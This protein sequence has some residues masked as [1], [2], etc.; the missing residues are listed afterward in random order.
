MFFFLQA[1]HGIRIY[2]VTGVRTCALPISQLPAR[3]VLV[4]V[5]TLREPAHVDQSRVEVGEIQPQLEPQRS[6]PRAKQ[7]PLLM[8]PRSEER[9]VGKECRSRWAPYH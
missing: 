7:K 1:E 5:V 8:I 2:K 3:A 9:R 6:L 4:R